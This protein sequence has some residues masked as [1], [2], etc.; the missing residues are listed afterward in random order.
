MEL[1]P[2][3]ERSLRGEHGEAI[4][5]AYRILAAIGEATE[6][7]KL[8]PI[9]WAHLSGVNYNTIGNAG[10][11]FLEKFAEDGATRVAVK[12]TVNP[13]GFDR[14]K[15]SN[16]DENFVK[17][18]MKIVKLYEELGTT[19]SF[20]CAPYEIFDIPQSGT[21]VSFAESSAAIYSNSILGLLT[22]KESSLSA[23]A[24]SVTGKAPYS[25]LRVEELRHPKIAIKPEL[26][27]LTELDYGLF[28]YFTGKVVKD[29]CVALD[30]IRKIKPDIMKT[31]SLS[32]AIGTSGTCGMFTS[33]EEE[34]TKEVIP[35]DKTQ[36]NAARDELH[37]AE[38]GSVII[39]GSP[40]IGIN[41]LSLVVDL[42]KNK[43]FS[44]RCMI[45]C[46][47]AI[48]NQATQIG[49][50]GK[51]ERAGGEFMCDSCACLTPLINKDDVDSIVTNSIKAA[52]YM[53]H[54]N[55]TG[56]ALKDLK[57]IV[58]DYMN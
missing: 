58:K 6:A 13:M 11:K 53:K 25:E 29:S 45:F 18:Q 38:D 39:L 3:D 36:L 22:N 31:K 48:F 12:T 2:D 32:A 15:P 23:L 46:S 17:Q 49:L 35:F 16:L 47:R 14:T 30:G 1:T 50:A 26:K 44:K 10:V 40:Q 4:A 24:S 55:R 28:G 41:E 54:F 33:S 56:V 21:P 42:A 19:P 5:S 27:L 52:Y 51:I 9:K 20:T 8:V 34:S 57:T 43:K 7:E 37:T